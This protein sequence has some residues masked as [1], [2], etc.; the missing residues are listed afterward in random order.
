MV[1][2]QLSFSR[3]DILKM[4]PRSFK[5]VP[6]YLLE[7]D[8]FIALHECAHVYIPIFL[9]VFEFQIISNSFS[10]SV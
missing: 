9:T 10:L 2:S 3:V 7:D 8:F 5:L 4:K 1:R 6:R